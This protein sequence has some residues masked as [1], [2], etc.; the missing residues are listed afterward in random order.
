MLITGILTMLLVGAG[1]AAGSSPFLE[2][3]R[4]DGPLPG[5]AERMDLYAPLL[6]D[7]S[8]EVIDH[9]PDGSLRTSRG[10]VHFAWVL[11]GRAIQDVWIVPARDARRPGQPKLGNRYGTTLRVYD[12]EA[13]VWNVTWINPVTGIS[14]HLVGRRQGDDILQEGVDTDGS[15]IRWT[16]TEVTRE[17]FHWRGEASTDAGKTWLLGAEFLGRRIG[18]GHEAHP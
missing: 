15:L 4:A 17:S 3:L 7:W 18:P 11:E 5:L 12:P 6:G 13:D 14:N 2:A 9:N 8:V 10:E 16:F 1:E